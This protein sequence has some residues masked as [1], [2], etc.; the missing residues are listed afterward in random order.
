MTARRAVAP[1][2]V[3]AGDLVDPSLLTRTEKDALRKAGMWRLSRRRGGYGLI[4][5]RWTVTLATV[6][7]LKRLGLVRSVIGSGR[8][9]LL[10]TGSGKMTLAI[11]DARA[12][13]ARPAREAANG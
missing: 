4:G 10:I 9:T 5:E 8:N 3:D 2:P 7:V 11:M 6:R 13:R 1:P 12:R